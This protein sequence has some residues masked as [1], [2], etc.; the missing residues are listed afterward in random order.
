[1][2]SSYE[3]ILGTK[4]VLYSYINNNPR[5]WFTTAKRSGEVVCQDPDYRR[6]FDAVRKMS[7]RL[8]NDP[9]ANDFQETKLQVWQV[10][11]C[12][13]TYNISDW[14]WDCY[15]FHQP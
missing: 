2:N 3:I 5:K 14:L 6:L 9:R 15:Q 11:G 12:L 10:E 7:K 13:K 8:V 4:L 1:M